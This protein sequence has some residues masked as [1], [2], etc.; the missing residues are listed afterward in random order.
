[1]PKRKPPVR[2]TS[3]LTILRITSSTLIKKH[4]ERRWSDGL[5]K[6]CLSLPPPLRWIS[7]D[8]GLGYADESC[9]SRGQAWGI[10]G[11]AQCGKYR[12]VSDLLLYLSLTYVALRSGRKDFLDIS[13]RLADKFLSLLGP[14]GVPEWDFD[15]PKPCPYD[16]SAATITARGLQML[17]QLLL[18]T[19]PKA[20]E[21]YLRRGFKLVED[22]LK[23][24]WASDASLEDGQVDF[25]QDGWE[26]ILSVS[27]ANANGPPET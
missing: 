13:R 24:C 14:T 5:I 12:S 17:Y 21:E 16:A 19:D 10:Y 3:D 23:E 6:V 22:T 2:P 4:E 1:M 11:Y 27:P 9:W 8:T 7:T 26:T 15:A 25:G 18:P 20:A